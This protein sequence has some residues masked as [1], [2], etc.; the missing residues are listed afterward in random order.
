MLKRV[1]K[2]MLAM[3]VL[4]VA[5]SL[6]VVGQLPDPWRV[7]VAALAG[8]A[9]SLT[10]SLLVHSFASYEQSEMVKSLTIDAAGVLPLPGAFRRLKWFAYATKRASAEGG[11]ITEWRVVPLSRVGGSGPRF[12][13]YRVQVPNLV[14]ENVTYDAT[15][16]GLQGCVL[17]TF[18]RESETSSSVIFDTHVPDAGLFF[19]AAYL[20]DWGGD[21]DITLSMVGTGDAP[22][23]D[24]LPTLH[25]A[26]FDE[27]YK[28]VDWSV[29][30][31]HEIIVSALT[32]G[33]DQET[34][35]PL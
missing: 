22:V 3:A 33:A 29:E 2:V 14:G 13:T 23:I 28:K 10:A 32:R 24:K 5:A 26:V 15:F 17:A 11:K 35:Q 12:M 31:A 9:M 34:D 25:A 30:A 19:G 1:Y 4:I 6:L 8:G 7:V 21:R 20:T 27:W 18:T 16:I